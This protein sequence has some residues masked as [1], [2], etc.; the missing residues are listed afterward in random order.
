MNTKNIKLAGNVVTFVKSKGDEK[1]IENK[2]NDVMYE[3]CDALGKVMSGAVSGGINAV[4]FIFGKT[5][6]TVSSHP[7]IDSKAIDLWAELHKPDDYT[8]I[9]RVPLNRGVTM[10]SDA[11]NYEYNKIMFTAIVSVG[12]AIGGE[13]VVEATDELND[14]VLVVAPDINDSTK[15]MAYA[16]YNYDAPV[17]ITAETAIGVRW[18]T[19]YTILSE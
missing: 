12:D 13:H 9:V 2:H 7:E 18:D 6:E 14:I 5:G 3:G 15:D 19:S 17:V 11:E 8:Y 16:F 4:Y 1:I 10:S